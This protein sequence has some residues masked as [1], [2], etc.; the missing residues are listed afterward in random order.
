[1]LL[2]VTTKVVL[3]LSRS[4]VGAEIAPEVVAVAVAEVVVPD[5]FNV[6]SVGGF[7]DVGI[8]HIY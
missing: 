1:M 6:F 8:D 3:E 4:R 2:T 5:L 7:G